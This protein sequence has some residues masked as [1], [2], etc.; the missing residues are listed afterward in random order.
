MR[1]TAPPARVLL[2][3]CMTDF[4]YKTNLKK[5]R[6]ALHHTVGGTAISTYNYWI[7][8]NKHQ[9]WALGTAIIIERDGSIIQNFANENWA[10]QFGLLDKW[11]YTSAMNFEASSIGIEIASEG[12]AVATGSSGLVFYHGGAYMQKVPSG[13]KMFKPLYPFRGYSFFD[14]YDDKQIDSL[15]DL[16]NQLFDKFNIPRVRPRDYGYCYRE[17][18]IKNFE[19]LIGHCNVRQDKSDPIPDPDFWKR[20]DKGCNLKYTD[21][22]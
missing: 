18:D 3:V 14:A 13:H 5:R 19:G 22:P 9:D 1:R 15:I 8:K 11:K 6:I 12:P 20:L 16:L 21:L 10:Y 4:F 7:E 2:R 17:D